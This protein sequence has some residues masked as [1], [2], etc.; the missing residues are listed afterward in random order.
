MLK[1]IRH[2]FHQTKII[3]GRILSV[4]FPYKAHYLEMSKYNILSLFNL[5]MLRNLEIVHAF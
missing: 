1:L 4:L 2:V 3:S 5:K